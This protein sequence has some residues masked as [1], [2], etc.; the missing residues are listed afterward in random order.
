MLPDLQDDLTRAQN[1]L[2]RLERREAELSREE[3]S[4][5]TTGSLRHE[6]KKITRALEH[7]REA[8]IA[9]RHQVLF[10]QDMKAE[11]D[12]LHAQMTPE[13]IAYSDKMWR[14]YQAEEHQEHREH[15]AKERRKAFRVILGG[16][17]VS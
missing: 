10:L 12:E 14:E 5:P 11:I 2:T 9:A 6:W 16:R 4:L 7:I 1:E 17:A 15:Q 3:A 8:L 13:E